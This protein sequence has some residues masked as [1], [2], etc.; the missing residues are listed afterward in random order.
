MMSVLCALEA[1]K[2]GGDVSLVIPIGQLS[3]VMIAVISW[4]IFKEMM[5]SVK[6]AGILNA[7]LE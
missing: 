3:I 7:V 6:M 2:T 5:T 4:A 1:F